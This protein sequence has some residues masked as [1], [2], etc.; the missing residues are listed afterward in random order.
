MARDGVYSLM[1]TMDEMLKAAEAV[2][3]E[4]PPEEREPF[5]AEINRL[6]SFAAKSWQDVNFEGVKPT[7]YLLPDT[8]VFRADERRESLPPEVA[9]ANAPEAED[10]CFKVPRIIEE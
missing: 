1:I 3:L 7:T 10:G 9:L 2:R 4:T 5:L 8:N 6:F